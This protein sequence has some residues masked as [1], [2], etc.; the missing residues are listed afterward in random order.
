MLKNMLIILYLVIGLLGF[1][2]NDVLS[3]LFIFIGF[4][5]FGYFG[6]EKM[7]NTNDELC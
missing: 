6:T 7:I 4:F 2:G 3:I 1:M 5:G